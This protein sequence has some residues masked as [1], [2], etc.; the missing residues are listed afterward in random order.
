MFT[1]NIGQADRWIRIVLGLGLLS[2]LFILS[3]GVRYV[4]LIGLIPLITGAAGSCPLYAVFGV[5]TKSHK[6]ADQ[7]GL[8]VAK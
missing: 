7:A 4:G 5:S 2:L 3:G 6:S 1:Q 8:R